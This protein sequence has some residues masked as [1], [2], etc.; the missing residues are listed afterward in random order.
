MVDSITKITIYEIDGKETTITQP[1]ITV[2]NHWNR[3]D[4]V[5]IHFLDSRTVT[6][7]AEE[8]KR[9]IENATNRNSY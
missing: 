2:S 8:L 4:L 1:V 6:V 7:S 5:K 3:R 9:A